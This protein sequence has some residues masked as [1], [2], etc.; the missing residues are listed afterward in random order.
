MKSKRAV[1]NNFEYRQ[2]IEHRKPHYQNLPIATKPTLI[3]F[4][5]FNGAG[6]STQMVRVK[7]ELVGS[8]DLPIHIPEFNTDT[9]DIAKLLHHATRLLSQGYRNKLMNLIH[10]IYTIKASQADSEQWGKKGVILADWF[11]DC[12]LVYGE[13][14]SLLSAFRAFLLANN[15]Y[16]PTLSF[17]LSVPAHERKRRTNFRQLQLK[18]EGLPDKSW[19]QT[20]TEEEKEA[21]RFCEGTSTWLSKS[22]SYFH[23]IDGTQNENTVTEQIMQIVNKENVCRPLS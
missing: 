2:S 16:E 1:V 9:L 11:W 17:Y 21:D 5:G 20:E 4:D 8:I 13:D 15:G 14:D 3:T 7:Q 6:K 22:L 12:L 19:R 18:N 23:V 10:E